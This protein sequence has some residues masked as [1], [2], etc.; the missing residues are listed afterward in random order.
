MNVF[1]AGLTSDIGKYLC[2]RYLCDSCRIYGTY[3]S[4]LPKDMQEAIEASGGWACY[5]DYGERGSIR[6][7]CTSLKEHD[8]TWDLFISAIGTLEPI[9]KF[10]DVDFDAWENSLHVNAVS[11]LRMLQGIFPDRNKEAA[12]LFF[13][14]GGTN[15]AFTNYSAYCISKI[16]LIKMTELLS[17]EN[18][19]V[20]F[21]I[22]GPGMIGTKIHQTTLE[23]PEKAGNNYDKTVNYLSSEKDDILEGKLSRIYD[24]IEWMMHADYRKDLSGRNFAIEHDAWENCPEELICKLRDDFDMYKLRRYRNDLIVGK[25]EQEDAR[26]DRCKKTV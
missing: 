3:H 1:I 15:N 11:Q 23:H 26:E 22:L 9:G 17:D 25:G 21:L 2:K 19:D 8:C 14:G 24:F 16:L 5:C 18:P 13:A 12:V 20:T 7:A 10:M 6:H 4:P